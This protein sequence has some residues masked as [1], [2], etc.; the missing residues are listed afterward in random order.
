MR[1][2]SL[3]ILDIVHNSI[4]AG[5]SLIEV[6]ITED[7]KQNLFS[8]VIRDNGKGMDKELLKSV[9][10]PFTTSRST[11]KVG[12]GIP[13]FKLAAENTGGSFHITSEVGKGTEVTANFVHDSIDRQPLGDMAETML[14]LFSSY[15]HINVVYKHKLDENEFSVKTEELKAV[16]DGVSFSEPSIYM[17]LCDYLKNGENELL[18]KV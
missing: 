8:V 13:L 1:E 7:K 11:R 5:A 15:E 6:F 3:H 10:D 14:G 16:L 12:L 4:A 18:S 2:I 9:I 17:W